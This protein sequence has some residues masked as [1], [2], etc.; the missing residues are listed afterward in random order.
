VLRSL[1]PAEEIVEAAGSATD[2]IVVG[3]HCRASV[4]KLLMGGTAQ[5]VLPDAGCPVLAVTADQAD[6]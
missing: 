5:R 1:D 4:G 6:R 2:L 3:V